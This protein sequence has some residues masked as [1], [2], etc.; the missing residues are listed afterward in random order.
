MSK[1][2]K[3]TIQFPKSLTKE[4]I[5]LEVESLTTNLLTSE[6]NLM[7]TDV[8]NDITVVDDITIKGITNS[9]DNMTKKLIVSQELTIP[10]LTTAPTTG[11][12]YFDSNVGVNGSK[13]YIAGL[14]WKHILTGA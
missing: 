10:I 9:E 2:L 5:N 13:I 14:G 6:T 4:N 11:M 12:I 1:T 7:T 3:G 8:L